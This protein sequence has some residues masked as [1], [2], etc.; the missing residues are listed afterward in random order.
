VTPAAGA[1]VTAAAPAPHPAGPARRGG[2]RLVARNSGW[3]FTTFAAR[4]VSGIVA[5]ALVGRHG[6]PAQLGVYQ[7]ALALSLMFSFTVGLGLFNLLTR[8]VA[9]DPA[10]SRT[11]IEAGVLVALTA[12]ALTTAGLT[13]A[14]HLAGLPRD[15]IQAVTLAGAALAFDTAGR[16]EFAAFAAWERMALETAATCLQE[17]TFLGGAVLALRLGRGVGGVLLAYAATRL[18]G[19]LAGW[20]MAGRHLGMPVVPRPHLGFL[21]PTLRRT[22]PFALDDAMSLTYI[23]VDAVLLGFVKGATAVGLYTACT[24]LVLYLNV[25][26]RVLNTA[27]FPRMSRAW[28]DRAL[29]GRY[30]DLSLRLLGV[31]G[32]PA[33][34]GSLL[35]AGQLLRFVYGGRY[36]SAVLTYQVLIL[37]IPIRMLGHTLGTALTAANG[38][39]RR[40]VA[41]A[42]AAALN[43][44]LNLWFIP[45]HSYLGA[46]ETT[47]I[48]ESALFV[49]YALLLRRVAGRSA[50]A[51]GVALPACASLPMAGL[52]L[53]LRHA[54]LP[55]AVAAGAGAYLAALL[56]VAALLAPPGRRRQPRS[57]LAALVQTAA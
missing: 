15:M 49:T 54:P 34:V 22:I 46:A 56:A 37:V 57:L 44:G 42:A 24:N 6:G 11:W 1:Q 25:L 23:R 39:T 5:V 17:A 31:V 10:A 28:P 7:F 45:H 48:T 43:L 40:T 13:A 30:R 12:G 50:L 14:V 35:L 33:M 41:V 19:A 9:R 21:G 2:D 8:E 55:A 29:L 20:A 51:A 27:L 4:A 47:A 52:L 32:V 36:G 16:I 18:L 3:Q 38:Q 53:L 26:A